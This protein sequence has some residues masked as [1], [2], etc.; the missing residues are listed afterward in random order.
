[1]SIVPFLP[2]RNLAVSL[3]Q[4]ASLCAYPVPVS[5]SSLSFHPSPVPVGHAMLHPDGGKGRD[6]IIL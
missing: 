3:E 1:M 2:I 5:S 4:T 6:R